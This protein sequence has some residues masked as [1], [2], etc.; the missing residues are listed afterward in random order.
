MFAIDNSKAAANESYNMVTAQDV[1]SVQIDS[2]LQSIGLC[3][4]SWEQRNLLEPPL[5]AAASHWLQL[6][7]KHLMNWQQTLT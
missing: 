1:P 6:R 7:S 2:R 3:C 5:H 4:F